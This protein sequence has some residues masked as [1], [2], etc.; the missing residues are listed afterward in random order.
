MTAQSSIVPHYVPAILLGEESARALDLEKQIT[1][2]FD[3]L[4]ESVYRYLLCLGVT[5]RESQ[6]V[7]QETFLRLCKYIQAGGRAHHL[8]GWV[9][10]VAHNIAVN[11]F[12]RRKYIIE[13]GSE[14][15]GA[16]IASW[17][18]PAPSPEELL[19]R[20]EKI[21][22]VHLAISTLSGQQR[23]CLY[24]RAEGFRYREIAE[25][26]GVTISTVAES[27]RRALAKLTKESHV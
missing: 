3:E 14:Q 4:H 6:E 16:L 23:N 10:R 15:F 26:L 5:E 7:V 9:F 24:L 2:L 20:R 1:Q 12:K 8:R 18:D 25:I 19:M 17:V 11:E 22:R 13:V 27:L 21:A